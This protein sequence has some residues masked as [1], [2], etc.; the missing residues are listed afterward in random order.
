MGYRS[1][2]PCP[3]NLAAR[4]FKVARLRLNATAHA[5]LTPETARAVTLPGVRS[6]TGTARRPATSVGATKKLRAVMRSG[7]HKNISAGTS[8]PPYF[9]HMPLGP[10]RGNLAGQTHREVRQFCPGRQS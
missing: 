10:Q 6:L 1:N 2:G 8:P 9:V 5:P 4:S 7:S 3:N